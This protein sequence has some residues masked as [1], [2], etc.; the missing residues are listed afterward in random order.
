[1]IQRYAAPVLIALCGLCLIIQVLIPPAVGIANNGDFPKMAGPFGLGPE[2][3]SWQSHPDRGEFVYR[4]VR[5]DRYD[6]DRGFRTAGFLSSEYFFVK[7][8]RGLQ[9]ILHPGPRFDIRW[10]GAVT[11]AFFLFAI[12]LWICALP[13]RWRLFAGLLLVF[14]WTDVAYVQYFNS[15][16]MDTA[17]LVGLVLTVAAGLHAAKDATSRIY[18]V[19]MS[20]GAALFAA[21]KSQHSLPALLFLPLFLGWAIRSRGR[22]ARALWVSGSALLLIAVGTML[23]R[24]DPFWRTT[25]V[26]NVVFERI[27]PESPDPLRALEDLGLGRNELPLVRTHA[28]YPNSPMN[29][30][31]RVKQFSAKCNYQTL[32]V[33][34]LAHP[35][36]TAHLLYQDIT[37]F[38]PRMRPYANLSPTDGYRQ[39]AQVAHFTYWSDLRGFLLRHAPW[40]IVLLVLANLAGALW[41]LLRS[42][43]DRAF[44]GLALSIQIVMLLEL[45]V[46]ALADGVDTERHLM[47][48]NAATEISILLLPLLVSKVIATYPRRSRHTELA[49][50][51]VPQLATHARLR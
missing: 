41:L 21:S 20:A 11:A 51:P 5:A 24:D 18:P 13:G 28:F 17:A 9:R 8:A 43:S 15:F 23:H 49:V 3:G 44:A 50:I 30:P 12:G 10:L 46:A 34:F 39:G 19:L 7:A 42:I 2:D 27:A 1:M 48:F 22:A 38:A 25:A 32:L 26:F 31:I 33:H 47:I 29:D 37:R 6:Y 14:I 40:H 4:Y 35:S 45:A 16:F 36:L